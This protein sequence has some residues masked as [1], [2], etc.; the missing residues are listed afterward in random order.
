M[1]NP[2]ALYEDGLSIRQ[3]LNDQFNIANLLNN[4]AS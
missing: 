2:C 3:Q 1:K 4:M